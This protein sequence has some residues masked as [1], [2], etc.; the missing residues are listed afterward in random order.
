MMIFR[1][2]VQRRPATK[3]G[4]VMVEFIACIPLLALV[5]AATYFFGW[6]MRN[7]QRM[8]TA[9][10][11][12]AWRN[13]HGLHNYRGED[14]SHEY[15]V[16][17][18]EDFM[19]A[20]FF[21][22]RTSSLT[23]RGSGRAL[24]TPG[25]W[26]DHAQSFSADA[27]HLASELTAGRSD[28]EAGGH[29]TA[30]FQATYQLWETLGPGEMQAEHTREDDAWPRGKISLVNVVNDIYLRELDDAISTLYLYG[31]IQFLYREGW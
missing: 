2:A 25:R 15:S 6:T 5:V 1:R 21:N 4:T 13:Y 28:V 23:I 29:I 24:E 12:H 14:I 7:Q 26:A 18:W 31:N 27:G 20:V 8:V 30:D 19:D 10:R 22:R 16:G 3:R 11:Y 9:S 17:S